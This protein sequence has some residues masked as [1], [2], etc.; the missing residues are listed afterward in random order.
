MTR[1]RLSRALVLG[2]LAAAIAAPSLVAPAAA[3]IALPRTSDAER[4][5]DQLN[6]AGAIQRQIGEMERH[7]RFENQMMRERL[8]RLETMPPIA[9]PPPPPAI[10]R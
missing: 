4:T 10:H 8:N 1:T 7:Q 5:V 2:L 6:R 9:P 3:Q